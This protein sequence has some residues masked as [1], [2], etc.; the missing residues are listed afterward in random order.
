MEVW[1]LGGLGACNRAA[2][3]QSWEPIE[4]RFVGLE[5]LEAREPRGMEARRPGGWEN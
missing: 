1:K 3:F 4:N 2:M 5:S